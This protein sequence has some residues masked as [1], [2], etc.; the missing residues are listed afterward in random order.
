V[1]TGEVVAGNIGSERR[2]EYTVIGDAVNVASRLE[3]STKDLGVG[4]LI[5]DD[6]WALCEGQINARPLEELTVKG[7]ARPVRAYE[8]LG[9]VGEP[10]IVAEAAEAKGQGSAPAGETVRGER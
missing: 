8:V 3:S 7:R 1:H 4:V 2:M 10:P 6:T 5:S 9:I